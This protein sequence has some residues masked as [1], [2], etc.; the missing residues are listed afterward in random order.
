[1]YIIHDTNTLESSVNIVI[2]SLHLLLIQ[3]YLG[4]SWRPTSRARRRCR[5]PPRAGT[6]TLITSATKNVPE[7]THSITICHITRRPAALAPCRSMRADL[8][9]TVTYNAPSSSRVL[10]NNNICIYLI[11]KVMKSF[12][13]ESQTTS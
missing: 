12:G 2:R 7:T 8:T 6:T 1:M 10:Y 4:T 9:A 3:I 13:C 11:N 5:C